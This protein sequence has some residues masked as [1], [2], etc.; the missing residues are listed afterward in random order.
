M[1]ILNVGEESSNLA[2]HPRNNGIIVNQLCF[3]GIVDHNVNSKR[4][5]ELNNQI[6]DKIIAERIVVGCNGINKCSK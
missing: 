1:K 6:R 4:D 2:I 5:F 3:N